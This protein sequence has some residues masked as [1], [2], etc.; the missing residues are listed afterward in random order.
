[1]FRK[2][3]KMKLS[4]AL[5]ISV[6]TMQANAADALRLETGLFGFSWGEEASV[7]HGRFPQANVLGDGGHIHS[8]AV[9]GDFLFAGH[10]VDVVL[11]RFDGSNRLNLFSF[12]V[13]PDEQSVLL[14][15]LKAWLGEPR[16][17][18]TKEGGR[19]NHIIEWNRRPVSV[20]VW[21]VTRGS[22]LTDVAARPAS[23]QVQQ[24]PLDSEIERIE[25]QKKAL[26]ERLG[27]AGQQP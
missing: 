5:L 27:S 4:L 15:Q 22:Q 2:V 1:M 11:M 20:S 16:I 14:Q 17:M 21:A 24:G 6:I 10:R 13:H 12:D 25:Q 8:L 3:L 19:F 23:I 18:S 9:K 7:I 26:R